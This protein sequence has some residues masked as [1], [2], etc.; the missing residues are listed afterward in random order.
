LPGVAGP[1]DDLLYLPPVPPELEP[2]RREE[3]RRWLAAGTP[4]LF[5]VLPS[6]AGSGRPEAAGGLAEELPSVPPRSGWGD[7]IGDGGLPPAGTTVVVDLLPLLLAGGG[8]LVAAPPAPPGAV[9]VWPLVPGLGD[10]PEDWRRGCERLAAA[11]YAT[12][13]PLGLGLDPA[14]RRR[15]AERASE[16]AYHDLFHRPPPAERDFSRVA[17]GFGLAPFL[18]RPGT[19]RWP[20][21]RPDAP[22]AAEPPPGSPVGSAAGSITPAAAAFS[23]R[24]LA[25]LLALAGELWLRVGR[26]EA[27]GQ[28]LFRAARWADETG[29]DLAALAREGNLGVVAALDQTSR[30]LIG[31]ALEAAAATDEPGDPPLVTELLGEY[32]EAGPEGGEDGEKAG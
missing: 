16:S 30:E 18:R 9:A 28:A 12:V 8:E 5:Q 27:Q 22:P 10:R 3:A 7:E 2:A 19:E 13:Q 25:G 14:D 29:Y 26:P 1:L 15:L 21:A 6:P 20:G 17:A 11:G 31:A 24:R 32:L 4:V 23:N